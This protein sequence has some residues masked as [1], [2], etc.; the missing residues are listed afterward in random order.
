MINSAERSYKQRDGRTDSEIGRSDRALPIVNDAYAIDWQENIQEPMVQ[1]INRVPDTEIVHGVEIYEVHD[2]LNNHEAIG[3]AIEAAQRILTSSL[4]IY[5]STRNKLLSSD[6]VEYRYRSMIEVDLD[7]VRQDRFDQNSPLPEDYKISDE[8]LTQWYLEVEKKIPQ[9]LELKYID[10]EVVR[11]KLN[12][13]P[14]DMITWNTIRDMFGIERE[15]TDIPLDLATISPEQ[16]STLIRLSRYRTLDT[17]GLFDIDSQVVA[18]KQDFHIFCNELSTTFQNTDW[19]VDY[20]DPEG[21]P[22]DYLVISRD[23]FE[24]VIDRVESDGSSLIAVSEE[25]KD[26]LV[27]EFSKTFLYANDR[28][29]VKVTPDSTVL[30]DTAGGLQGLSNILPPQGEFHSHNPHNR[31]SLLVLNSESP[32]YHLLRTIESIIKE[33]REPNQ[34]EW[35]QIKTWEFYSLMQQVYRLARREFAGEHLIRPELGISNEQIELQLTTNA[36]TSQTESPA[37]WYTAL[38][39]FVTRYSSSLE[40]L[41]PDDATPQC[42]ANAIAHFETD[43]T[44]H[45]AQALASINRERYHDSF[46]DTPD[47]MDNHFS[48]IITRVHNLRYLFPGVLEEIF[49]GV[50]DLPL[51]MDDRRYS[52]DGQQIHPIS[53][54]YLENNNPEISDIQKIVGFNRLRTFSMIASEFLNDGGIIDGIDS[55]LALI[56][57]SAEVADRS[58]HIDGIREIPKGLNMELIEKSLA[59]SKWKQMGVITS[60]PYRKGKKKMIPQFATSLSR[61]KD[62]SEIQTFLQNIV[63]VHIKTVNPLERYNKSNSRILN[64]YTINW[65]SSDTIKELARYF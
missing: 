38:S 46:A 4:Y 54:L 45:T 28:V 2:L 21:V 40:D 62:N 56:L 32:K 6:G 25:G 5:G 53:F 26:H 58:L 48:E 33:D 12:L 41:L 36:L 14:A 64:E 17:D 16:R 15:A 30:H 31:E 29:M 47:A 65:I 52:S 39:H 43:S 20:L 8:E 44:R 1:Q 35:D 37:Y 63:D 22:R 18:N 11:G 59:N 27:D 3:P 60:L 24:L 49:P 50:E 57:V 61:I 10:P 55:L 19:K 13:K 51:Y 7:K 23:G 9:K 42:R 34:D